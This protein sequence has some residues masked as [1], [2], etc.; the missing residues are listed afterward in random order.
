ML[1]LDVSDAL[2]SLEISAARSDLSQAADVHTL[3]MH[4][5]LEAE[6]MT[7]EDLL[8]IPCSYTCNSLMGLFPLFLYLFAKCLIK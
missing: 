1:G 8:G 7:G 5:Y 2:V 4:V 6:G 3:S